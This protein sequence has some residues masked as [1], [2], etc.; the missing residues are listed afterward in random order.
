[1][2]YLSLSV[3]LYIFFNVFDLLSGKII[4]LFTTFIYK[5]TYIYRLSLAMCYKDDD[6][7]SDV[8]II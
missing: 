2:I 1:M 5:I 6:T 8:K 4:G 7:H 3:F